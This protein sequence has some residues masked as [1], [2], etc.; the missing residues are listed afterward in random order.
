MNQLPK[1]TL[2]LLLTALAVLL[3]ACTSPYADPTATLP[4]ASVPS[5]EPAATETPAEGDPAAEPAVTLLAPAEMPTAMPLWTATCTPAPASTPEVSATEPALDPAVAAIVNGTPIRRD[6]FDAQLAQAETYFVQQPGFD[7]SSPTG[8]QA[9]LVLREQV[10]GWLI[11]QILIQQAAAAE[12]IA[13]PKSTVD[14]EV[15]RIRGAD[16]TRYT[17]W[18]KANGL[19]E[20]T[21]REQIWMDLLTSAMRD[22]VTANLPHRTEQVHARHILL[23]SEQAATEAL[24]S[25]QA[26]ADF[27]ALARQISE[28]EATRASGGDLGY[29]PR[30]VMPPAFEEAAFALNVGDISPVVRSDFGY[31]IITVVEIDPDRAVP[32][33]LWPVL[34]QRAFDD[35]LQAQRARATIEGN[36][37]IIR[38]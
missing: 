19:T 12:G 25:L 3:S 32:E 15:R 18:L 22:R 26:G 17:A 24:A 21:L 9:L 29:M 5:A 36:S 31:H 6:V 30:G 1:I 4:D 23:S 13:I 38:G 20:E 34:Q 33:E 27:G 8:Q 7:P 14:A 16:L 10:L 37:D 35:W 2:V 28:D 11:D